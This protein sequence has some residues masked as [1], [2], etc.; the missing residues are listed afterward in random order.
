MTVD[1]VCFVSASVPRELAMLLRQ[2]RR[3]I[4]ARYLF[5][6]IIAAM[7]NVKAK[8]PNPS[9]V[10]SSGLKSSAEYFL[11]DDWARGSPAYFGCG[12]M[13]TKFT[14]KL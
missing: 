3:L 14:T 9:I 1:I 7:P 2:L 6:N 5:F 13:F 4:I 11:I 12:A 10:I 8:M